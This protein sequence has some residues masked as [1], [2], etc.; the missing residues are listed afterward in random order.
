EKW[1]G[2]W[3][4][5]KKEGGKSLKGTNRPTHYKFS[6]ALI[7]SHITLSRGCGRGC[8]RACP[9][10]LSSGRGIGLSKSLSGHFQRSLFHARLALIAS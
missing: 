7:R 9:C 8:D 2:R 10:P 5:L 6:P 3:R 1:G 4:V